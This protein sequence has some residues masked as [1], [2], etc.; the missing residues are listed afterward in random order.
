MD[1]SRS[2]LKVTCP[3]CGHVQKKFVE[4]FGGNFIKECSDESSKIDKS[5]G[6]EFVVSFKMIPELFTTKIVNK[7]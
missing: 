3:Y 1:Y 2:T 4:L 6:K 7:D 5:C